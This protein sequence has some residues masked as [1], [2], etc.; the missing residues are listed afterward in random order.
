MAMIH[1]VALCLAALKVTGMPSTGTHEKR[2]IAIM[3]AA[4]ILRHALYKEAD[5]GR[6]GLNGQVLS[7]R[8]SLDSHV[9]LQAAKVIGGV[10]ERPALH[11]GAVPQL[12]GV[13]V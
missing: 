5:P 3:A 4:K 12:T 11:L 6:G 7:D 13:L 10:L 8:H 2:M 9:Q 1:T